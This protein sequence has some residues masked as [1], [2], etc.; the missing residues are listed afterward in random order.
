MVLSTSPSQNASAKQKDA[1]L[2]TLVATP[3]GNLKDLTFRALESLRDADIIVCEDTRVTMRL[4]EAYDLS[5]P[6][7]WTY[8]EHNAI[9]QRPKI[10]EALR[11]GSKIALI[12]DAGTP[13]ISDPGYKLVKEA[14]NCG[15]RIT[16]APGVSA[17][18]T[19]VSLSGLPTNS[20][21]FGGFLP[22]KSGERLR[23][24]KEL[25]C[26]QTTLVFYES[27][28]RVIKSL[29]DM[30]DCFQSREVVL[31]RELTK[32]Y[33]EILRGPLEDILQT[34]SSRSS[35]KGEVVLLIGPGPQ[36]A[37]TEQDWHDALAKAL[38]QGTLKE[39]V[40][41]ICQ[42]KGL[43]RRKVYEKALDLKKKTS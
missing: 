37:L 2:L 31:A 36:Q 10:L 27:A 3:I 6:S 35:L 40:A 15:F 21:Y 9:T 5:P 41:Q 18:T 25:C 8:H 20:F 19:A 33:E 38:G 34:L 24:F 29:T 26:L 22:R 23:L 7:L 32:Y 11:Q 12:S 42:E 13:L 4:L 28:R 1:G 30:R 14:Q 43:P 16:S 17:V 39:A